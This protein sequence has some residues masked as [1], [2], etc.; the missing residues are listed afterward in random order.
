MASGFIAFLQSALALVERDAPFCT[1]AMGA[2]LAR[3]R[4]VLQVDNER[5]VVL[6]GGRGV[7]AVSEP[8]T[9]LEPGPERAV[10]CAAPEALLA[11]VDGADL[12]GL[13]T[14]DCLRVRATPECAAVLFDVMGLFVEGCARSPRVVTLLAA[15]RAEVESSSKGA[16][17]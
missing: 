7:C 11:L 1:A 17:P 16:V 10:F 5:C 9:S 8:A 6:A 4:V 14:T 3:M 15:F 13:V 12:V 2:A